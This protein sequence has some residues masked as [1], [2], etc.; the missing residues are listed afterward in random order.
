M[1]L[2]NSS[3]KM[4]FFQCIGKDKY[5]CSI[6][7]TVKKST[8]MIVSYRGYMHN[9]DNQIVKDTVRKIIDT[10]VEEAV[11]SDYTHPKNTLRHITDA[12]LS[13]TFA[14][15]GLPI[16]PLRKHWQVDFSG[17]GSHCWKSS[18]SQLNG[19]PLQ[20]INKFWIEY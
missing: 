7:C 4:K 3:N 5:F 12:V 9:H 15:H 1:R 13:S 10:K 14:E 8:N 19:C 6:T 16:C 20:K 11:N 17:R 2:K 18:L